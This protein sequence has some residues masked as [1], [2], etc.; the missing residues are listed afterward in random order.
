MALLFVLHF[1]SLIKDSVSNSLQQSNNS[2]CQLNNSEASIK[3]FP[4]SLHRSTNINGTV[5]KGQLNVYCA[6]FEQSNVLDLL[7]IRV[8]LHDINSS[9]DS[10]KLMLQI[11]R[12]HPIDAISFALPTKNGD[13]EDGV[14]LPGLDVETAEPLFGN[15]SIYLIILVVANSDK[16][17]AYSISVKIYDRS[18]YNIILRAPKFS[19]PLLNQKISAMMPIAF[20]VHISDPSLR[21]LKIT[22]KSDNNFCAFLIVRNYS[23]ILL[24]SGMLTLNSF[25]QVTFTRKA[26]FMVLANSPLHV[27]VMMMNDRA[28]GTF[29]PTREH[30]RVKKFDIEFSS[31]Q[32]TSSYPLV[33]M[34][35]F[36]LTLSII[37]L[38]NDQ[39][40]PPLPTNQRETDIP[41]ITLS[42]E[43]NS[44]TPSS[45]TY[46]EIRRVNDSHNILVDIQMEKDEQE[47]LKS[48][49]WLRTTEQRTIGT[50]SNEIIMQT[51]EDQ[52]TLMNN[53]LDTCYY[54]MECSIVLGPFQAFNHVYS[55]VG[56]F[57]LGFLFF[58]LIGRRYKHWKYCN[59]IGYNYC[60][61]IFLNIGMVMCLEA[62]ASAFYH[63][64]PNPRIFHNDTLFVEVALVLLMVRLYFVRRGGVTLTRD[65]RKWL[66]CC[67]HAENERDKSLILKKRLLV[68]ITVCNIAL[69]LLFETGLL[70]TSCI[71]LHLIVLNTVGYFIYY[72]SCKIISGETI[73]I[74][75]SIYAIASFLLWIAA[76]Y[77][78]SRGKNWTGGNRTEAEECILFQYFDYHDIWHFISSLASFFSLIAVAILDDDVMISEFGRRPISIF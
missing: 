62:F 35:M 43:S 71:T 19:R 72:I 4:F 16:I 74:R 59:C 78:F 54:N 29:A 32:S 9:V 12:Y 67:W 76:F 73:L 63:I 64:C 58:I 1:T 50:D 68:C 23:T 7:R 41:L 46:Q 13:M 20:R 36:Y 55:N 3:I 28:C 40:M 18:Q 27:F 60:P 25:M 39:L 38:A 57:L 24:H 56:Y 11:T 42:D 47:F 15:R 51:F 17:L 8:R 26:S 61:N 53:N 31:L 34:T 33:M 65:W 48:T 69:A 6:N 10:S 77:F 21:I 30:N 22:V 37:F 70:Q 5:K 66:R 49:A 52:L 45:S 14:M 2:F 44:G 75:A